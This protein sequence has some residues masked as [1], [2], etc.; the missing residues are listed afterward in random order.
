MNLRE[1][2]GHRL[3]V[4]DVD[5]RAVFKPFTIAKIVTAESTPSRPA[6]GA[7][8]RQGRCKLIQIVCGAP[9]A[10]AELIGALAE[11]ALTFQASM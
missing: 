7:W 6:E 11:P 2:D 8:R 10:R 3:E 9:N 1:A 4:E 5:D